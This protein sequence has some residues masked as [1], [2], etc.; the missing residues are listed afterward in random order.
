M[1]NMD[2]LD[3]PYPGM[4]TAFEAHTGQSWTDSDWRKETAMW[5]AAWKAAMRLASEA[6]ASLVQAG[7]EAADVLRQEASIL[8]DSHTLYG[9]WDDDDRE[10]QAHYDQMLALADKLAPPVLP[11]N[12]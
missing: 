3:A 9:R 6:T 11:P 10:T 4:A 7:A 12:A 2:G 8:R 1:K 5:A